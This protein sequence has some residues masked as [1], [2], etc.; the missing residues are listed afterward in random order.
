MK[1]S[2]ACLLSFSVVLGML[3]GCGNS[4]MNEVRAWMAAEKNKARPT[5]KP[6]PEPKPY[7]A[8]EYVAAGG[9]EPFNVARLVQAIN[10]A[11]ANS[12]TSAL[13][14]SVAEGRRKQPLESYPLD[15]MQYVGMLQKDGRSVALI[16]VDNL[17][18]QVRI[19][20]FMGQNFGRVLVISES[21]VALREVAQDTVGEWVERNTTLNLQEGSK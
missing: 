1:R 13:Y 2:V 8:V 19:G 5:I 4:R 10:A 3:G 15:S 16:K 6:L 9:V 18:Y 12:P 17:L 20:D 14:R 21:Q 7:T 11:N